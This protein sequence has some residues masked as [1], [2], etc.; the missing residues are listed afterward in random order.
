MWRK[1]RGNFFRTTA[2]IVAG[3]TWSDGTRIDGTWYI[4]AGTLSSVSLNSTG[5]A[6]PTSLNV[7]GSLSTTTLVT[8]HL[9]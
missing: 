4:P 9:K 2:I 1:N 7:T 6:S 8:K 3:E 5:V